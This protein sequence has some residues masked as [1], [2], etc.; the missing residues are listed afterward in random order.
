MSRPLNYSLFLPKAKK[1][2]IV[3]WIPISFLV[4]GIPGYV[5]FSDMGPSPFLRSA[6]LSALKNSLCKIEQYSYNFASMAV[7]VTNTI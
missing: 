4:S 6:I 5:C 1:I 7:K 3:V 2:N